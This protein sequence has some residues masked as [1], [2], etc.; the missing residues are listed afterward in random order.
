MAPRAA[1]SLGGVLV[2]RF[3]DPV[4][5]GRVADALL[6]AADAEDAKAGGN[7]S[8]ARRWRIIAHALGD[9][10]DGLG[11]PGPEY[12]ERLLAGP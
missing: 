12:V 4:D 11:K 3:P 5:A 10:L 7:L 2:L 8:L 1:A 9:G 6:A